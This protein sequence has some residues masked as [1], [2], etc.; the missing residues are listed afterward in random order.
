MKNTIEYDGKIF[1]IINCIP[2]G[3]QIWNIGEFIDGY[4]P[5]C[6]LKQIQPF[7]GC[8]EIETDTLKAIKV[9]GAQKILNAIGGR[10]KHY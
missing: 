7:E 6:K 9:D 5:L 2:L 10:T 1:E 4:L 3:Y 8:T